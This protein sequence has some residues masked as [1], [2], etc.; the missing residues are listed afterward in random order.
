MGLRGP[1]LLGDLDQGLVANA[2]LEELDVSRQTLWRWRREGKIPQ[3]HRYRDAKVVFTLAEAEEVRQFAN[4][5][6]PIGDVG[7]E[8]LA[9]F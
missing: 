9:L 6:E 5:V 3:G 8:Q 2:L 7:R 4:R 1:L